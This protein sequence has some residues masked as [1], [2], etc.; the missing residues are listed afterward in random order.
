MKCKYSVRCACSERSLS[1]ASAVRLVLA[2]A[3]TLGLCLLRRSVSRRFGHLAA[4][5]FVLLTC[6]QFHVPF[7]MGRTLPNMFAFLPG[8]YLCLCRSPRCANRES[9]AVNVLWSLLIDRA[10]RWKRPSAKTLHA[11]IAL[12]TFTAVVFRA[13]IALLL[14]PLV[15][16]ALLLRYVSFGSVVITGLLSVVLST[17]RSLFYSFFIN[18]FDK[19]QL[20]QSWLIHIFGPA[21]LFGPNSPVSTSTLSMAKHPIGAYVAFF[22]FDWFP[23][24]LTHPC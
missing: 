23:K 7:W 24:M 19:S 22:F 12:L 14:A 20:L 21:G 3:N 1:N 17:C 16:Q 8:T 10:P 4:V 5:L 13:E 18:L 6:S 11:S 2:T 9:I 15:L